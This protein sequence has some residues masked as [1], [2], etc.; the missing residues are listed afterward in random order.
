MTAPIYSERL[1]AISDEQFAAAVERLGLGAFVRAE[2]ARS[3]LFGQNAFVT[4]SAGE[5]VFRG[6]PHWV[7][8][9]DESEYRQEDRWQ[10]AKEAFFVEQLHKHTRAPVPWPYLRDERYDIFGWPYAIMP[11]MPGVCFDDRTI[12]KQTPED[13]RAIAAAIGAMLAQMQQLTSPFAGDFDINTIELTPYPGGAVQSVVDETRRNARDAG[14]HGA[15][16][17]DDHAW[18]EQHAQRALAAGARP[19]AYVHCDYK[20]N[21]LTVL[22][23][24][25][26]W[27]GAGLF[28]FHE[29]RFADGALDLVRQACSY[30]DSDPALARL[31]ADA[32]RQG[33]GLSGAVREVMPLYVVND[34]LKLW[35]YFSRPEIRA[36]W[37][38]GR[39]FRAFAEPYVGAI[40]ALL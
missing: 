14:A 2:P 21:N 29:A 34:R 11:R 39:T 40:T 25:G 10:F 9:P 22:R 17:A 8:G 35:G 32:Y 33:G 5:F 24:A 16:T 38:Q 19:V 23:E 4:T 20:L 13:Q 15:M 7:K 28:D 12:R 36:E 26:A 37:T 6:A 3:G 1:G 27:R 18:I 30:L 31:F